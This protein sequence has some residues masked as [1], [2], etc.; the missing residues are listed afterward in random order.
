MKATLT[1]LCAVLLALLCRDTAVAQEEELEEEPQQSGVVIIKPQVMD[2]PEQEPEKD[3]EYEYKSV[4]VP[5]P[6]RKESPGEQAPI[7]SVVAW[8][9][10]LPGTPALPEGWVECNGQVLEMPDSPYNGQTIPNLNGANDAP[11]RFL[12]GSLETGAE[13][14]SETHD[15]GPTLVQRTG[16][17]RVNVSARRPV[18]HLPPYYEVT[19]IMRVK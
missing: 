8:L 15:H 1:I 6:M 9:K 7:G 2:Q 13:G 18:K 3:P 4:T 12:R 10:S 5:I 11:Q 17:R 14:G 19:W 16:D